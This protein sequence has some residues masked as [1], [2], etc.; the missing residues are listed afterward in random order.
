MTND[1]TYDVCVIGGGPAGSTAA[2]FIAMCGHRVLLLEREALPV[3]KIGES[4]L[5]STIHGIC[6]M[7]GV[8]EEL[9]AQNFIRK[10]GGTFRWGKSPEPWTFA[11][12]ESSRFPGPTSYAYQVERIKFDL[13][14]LNN[15]KRKGVEVREEHR[16]AIRA[17]R[18]HHMI[19]LAVCGIGLCQHSGFPAS[20]RD[21]H[22]A[23]IDVVGREDDGIVGAP[24]G[25]AWCA[26]ETAKRDRRPAEKRRLPELT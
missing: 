2:T 10:L 24:C 18:R 11:F 14:L 4:L 13:V 22:Q 16:A 19:L 26:L 7:L 1:E 25:A 12:A 21:G 17:K 9:K 3:Y 5:P 6:A 8:T 20:R 23:G 15:A